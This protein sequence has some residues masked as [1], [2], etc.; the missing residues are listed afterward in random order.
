LRIL[1]IRGENLASLGAPF[2]LEF[3][4]EPLRAAGLFAITGE[5]G[6]GKSTILDAL[7]LA[8]YDEFPRSGAHNPKERVLDASGEQILAKDP[9]NI[10]RRGA[11]RGFAEA[12][13]VARDGL[14][15]RARCELRRARNRASGVLQNRARGLWRID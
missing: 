14:R 1:A 4:R 10:L 3:E 11:G 2:A 15:Y 7:C 8:L 9:G 12:D 5:T 13:F 6:A